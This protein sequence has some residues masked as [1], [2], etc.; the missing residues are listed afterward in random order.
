[1]MSYYRAQCVRAQ[2]KN[3]SDTQREQKLLSTYYDSMEFAKENT[4]RHTHIILQP[5]QT[6]NE[7]RNANYLPDWRDNAKSSM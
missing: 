4:S 7:A 3:G 1:M 2:D 5:W 6:N